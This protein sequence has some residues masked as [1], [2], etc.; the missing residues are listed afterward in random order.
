MA[1]SAKVTIEVNVSGL[2]EEI[3]ISNTKTLTVPVEVMSGYTVVDTATS[4]ALQL[5]TDVAKIALAKVYMVYLKAEV[6]TIYISVDTAGTDS[7]SS[8][9]ADLV[10]NVGESCVLPVNPDGNL[11]MVIDASA[12]TDAFSWIIL[13]KA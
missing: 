7:I 10:L 8:A 2:G 5:F 12:V 4:T 13:G 6:G 1:G 3:S 11:G 9:T